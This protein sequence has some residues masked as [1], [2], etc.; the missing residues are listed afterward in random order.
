MKK[1]AALFLTVLIL[2]I[3]L[4]PMSASAVVVSFD[5]TLTFNPGNTRWLDPDYNYAWLDQLFVRAGKDSVTLTELVPTPDDYAYSHTYQDFIEECDRYIALYGIDEETVSSV[6]S[7][8]IDALY[9]SVVA[10]GMSED[11][12]E[13]CDYLIRYGIVLPDEATNEE[14][15]AI[16][17]VYAAIEYNAVYVIYGKELKLSE[18]VTLER[19]LVEILAALT[20]TEVPANVTTVKGLGVCAVKQYVTE[21]EDITVPVSDDPSAEE[22]FYWLKVAVATRNG[23]NI[24]LDKYYKVTDVDREYVDYVYFS[25]ILEMEYEVKVDAEALLYAQQDKDAYAVHRLVL[26]TMLKEKGVSY[27]KSA[28]NEKLF[29]LACQNGYFPLEN[30]FFSDVLK[31]E[32]QVAPDCEKI[33]FTPITLGD[34]LNGGDKSPLYLTLQGTQIAPG[35]TN[36]VTLDTSKKQETVTLE[37]IYSGSDRQESALYEFKIIKNPELK[38]SSSASSSGDAVG[39]VQDFVN[40]VVPDNEKASQIVSDI[41]SVGSVT[42]SAGNLNEDVLSTYSTGETSRANED[43]GY[44]FDYL[45]ELIGNIYPTDEN[46]NVITTKTY[47]VTSQSG[48][49]EEDGNIIYK[50]TQTVAQN[51]EIVAAPTSL[52]ALGGLLGFMMNKKHKDSQKLFEDEEEESEE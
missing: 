26:E 47:T 21:F 36:A 23:Y 52:I 5:E 37:V 33:W 14:K 9:Y 45:G 6:Y 20:A 50:V 2:L 16:A 46:G 22:L 40:S 41:F 27:S 42:S 19:A 8:L 25:S 17:I 7:V 35:S 3:S 32:I 12:E 51:P 4:L 18:N 44:D 10:M 49:E 30:E 11:F 43:S 39:Q 28:T 48:E 13:M 34:Q 29:E 1:A 24:P 31:Y 15:M 38:S